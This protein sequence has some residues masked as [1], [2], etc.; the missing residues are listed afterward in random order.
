MRTQT[1]AKKEEKTLLGI[2]CLAANSW[3]FGGGK[4][5]LF[6]QFWQG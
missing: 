2:T 4:K 6:R 3:N 5:G 1:I